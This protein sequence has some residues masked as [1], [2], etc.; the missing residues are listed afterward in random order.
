MIFL[1]SPVVLTVMMQGVTNGS[2]HLSQRHSDCL[3]SQPCPVK[4]GD[5]DLFQSGIDAGVGCV[6]FFFFLNICQKI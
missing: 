5:F 1:H 3:V 6:F 4:T 2:T